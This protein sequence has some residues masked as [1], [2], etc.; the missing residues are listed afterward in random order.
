MAPLA[1]LSLSAGCDANRVSGTIA[2]L[3]V[4]IETAFTTTAGNAFGSDDLVVITAT[5]VPSACRAFQFFDETASETDDPDA[6]AEAWAASFPPDFWQ[7]DIVLRIGPTATPA[8]GAVWPALP[9]DAFPEEAGQAFA[10]FTH[11]TQHRDAASF[12][13]GDDGADHWLSDGGAVRFDGVSAEGLLDGRLNTTVV[14]EE[15]A[16]AGT[17][18]VFFKATPCPFVVS[19]ATPPLPTETSGTPSAR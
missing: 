14:D 17:V 9:V 15:G 10:T 3:T 11:T 2:G 16:V 18:Q 6:L 7:I 19:E 12:S 4:P 5:S 8:K 13:S 1:L